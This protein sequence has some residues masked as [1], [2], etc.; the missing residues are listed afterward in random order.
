MEYFNAV[1]FARSPRPSRDGVTDGSDGLRDMGAELTQT[2]HP[3]WPLM[4]THCVQGLPLRSFSVAPVRIKMARVCRNTM[5]DIFGHLGCHSGAFQTI[6]GRIGQTR[7]LSDAIYPRAD[8][9]ARLHAC[10]R[11]SNVVG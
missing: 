7:Q 1:D 10:L 5:Y 8:F 6:H 11:V 9:D 2:H 4:V 3:Y